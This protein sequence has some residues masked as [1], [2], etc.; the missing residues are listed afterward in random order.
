M[1]AWGKFLAPITVPTGGWDFKIT[2]EDVAVIPAAT[3]A[4]VLHLCAALDTVLEGIDDSTVTVSSV[5]IVTIMNDSMTGV[6]W[7]DCSDALLLVLGFD[8]TES[9]LNSV[10]TANNPHTYGWYPGIISYGSTRGEG[11]ADDSTW[12]PQD[13]SVSSKAGDGTQTIIGPER[14][15]YR[16]TLR[17]ATIHKDEYNHPSRGAKRL[18]DLWRYSELFWYPD[19]ED[20]VVGT[21][22]T[23]GDPG[24]TTYHDDDTLDTAGSYYWLVTQNRTPRLQRNATHPDWFSIDLILNAE[25]D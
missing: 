5:G 21:Y 6:D 23:Q 15:E 8:E 10:V 18:M 24:P 20:G 1:S 3:Y 16:R 4:T 13:A 22:G 14:L 2:G 19:R 25:P 17:F 12:E 9:V 7:G 11:V